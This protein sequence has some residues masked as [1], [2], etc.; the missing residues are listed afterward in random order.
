MRAEL[1]ALE[2]VYDPEQERCW[3]QKYKFFSG[4]HMKATY[5]VFARARHDP[6]NKDPSWG[7]AVLADVAAALAGEGS[8]AE[9]LGKSLGRT[10]EG[11][12]HRAEMKKLL[13]R[14]VPNLSDMEVATM[15]NGF[16][17]AGN[18]QV[19]VKDFVA[20]IE[21]GRQIKVPPVAKQRWRNPVHRLQRYPPAVP[22]GWDHLED[23]LHEVKPL[24]DQVL[25][26]E[27]E[28]LLTAAPHALQHTP[29]LPKY[30]NFGGG[31]DHDRF[32]RYAWARE[33]RNADVSRP[34]TAASNRMSIPDPGGLDLR[35]GYLCTPESKPCA[36]QL[37]FSCFRPATPR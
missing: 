23:G 2:R 16:H 36:K 4:N 1:R 20:T 30:S 6:F 7:K 35:P 21:Q 37:G 10:L 24:E 9:E 11:T 33:R 27:L 32:R 5:R 19:T 13:L 8:V 25:P 29:V 14:A 15:I 28:S 34:A 3:S 31:C 22:D 12:L 18:G 26:T 17:E